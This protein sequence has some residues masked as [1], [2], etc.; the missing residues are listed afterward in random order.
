MSSASG[1]RSVEVDQSTTRRVTTASGVYTEV[2]MQRTTA[3]LVPASGNTMP[4]TY[5]LAVDDN[6]GQQERVIEE[7]GNEG[8]N[9]S[10]AAG[11][12]RINVRETPSALCKCN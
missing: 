4:C 5:P 1:Y 11:K 2:R 3:Y 6:F 10:T 8:N 7:L 12:P 9:A